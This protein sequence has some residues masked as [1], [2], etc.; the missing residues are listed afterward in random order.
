MALRGPEALASLDEAIRDVRREEDEIAKR[1]ARSNEVIAKF[2]ETEAELFRQLAMIRIDPATQGDLAGSISQAESKAR[3][4]MKAH[5]T[6]LA[7]TE[8]KLRAIDAE[9]AALGEERTSALAE[10]DARA[11]EL[12]GLSARIAA[13]IGKDPGF[14]AKRNAAKEQQAIAEE[15]MG[16]TAQAEADQDSKGMPYRA[17]PLCRY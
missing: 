7:E 16:K 17:D 8:E 4:L 3:E 5:Q 9:I 10:V 6:Q 11:A 2:R 15:A 12:N 13:E 14:A 1:L